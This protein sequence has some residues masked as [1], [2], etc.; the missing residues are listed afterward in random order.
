VILKGQNLDAMREA[1]RSLFET[2]PDLRKK[3]IR[4]DV[5]PMTLE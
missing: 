5:N 2:M 1:V 4:I 3:D